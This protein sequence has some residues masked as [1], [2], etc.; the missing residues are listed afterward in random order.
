ML[1]QSL[2]ALCKVPGRARSIWKYLEALVRATGVTG[3]FAYGFRTDLHFADVGTRTCH[4]GDGKFSRTR[5][6][7]TSQLLMIISPVPS[8]LSHS[9]PQFYHH[10]RTRS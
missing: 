7:V 8:H 9:C 3:R 4:I 10:L 5:N 2:R 6:A 1:L